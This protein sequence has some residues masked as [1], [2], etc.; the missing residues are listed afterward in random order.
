MAWPALSGIP[1]AYQQITIT[2]GSPIVAVG[3]TFEP[4]DPIPDYVII[5][6]EGGSI[7]YRVDGQADPT[8]AIGIPLND[9]DLLNLNRGEAINFRAVAQ[10]TSDAVLYVTFYRAGIIEQIT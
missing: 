1:F 10:T 2:L 7:R 5:M 3:F 9:G 6:I 8:P 4:G